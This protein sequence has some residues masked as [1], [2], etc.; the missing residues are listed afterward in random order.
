MC[1]WTVKYMNWYWISKRISLEGAGL[2][3]TVM[4]K[5]WWGLRWRTI[6]FNHKEI[7]ENDW[8]TNSYY[9][10][11]NIENHLVTKFW[12][13]ILI[14]PTFCCLDLFYPI[15]KSNL[16]AETKVSWAE[17]YVFDYI[18]FQSLA[19]IKCW[20]PTA[21]ASELFLYAQLLL[22]ETER[23]RRIQDFSLN[24]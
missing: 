18:N 14:I 13:S 8:E 3:V 22:F 12:F 17:K 24:E 16:W 4:L 9:A 11:Y 5:D 23:V 19:A 6:W 1:P 10:D 2:R 21:L 20:V 7:S 15:L